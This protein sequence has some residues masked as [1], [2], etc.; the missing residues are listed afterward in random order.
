MMKVRV[1]FPNDDAWHDVDLNWSEWRMDRTYLDE[2]H[3][4]YRGHYLIVNEKIMKTEDEQLINGLR[5][6]HVAQII[7]R[8]MIQKAKPSGKQFKREKYKYEE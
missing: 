4:Y 5:P 6:R 7:R 2:V 3:G 8:K 1:R